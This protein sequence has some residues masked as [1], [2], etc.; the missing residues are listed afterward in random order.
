MNKL[1]L[2]AA[3]RTRRQIGVS[4][5]VEVI[6]FSFDHKRM[7]L[8]IVDQKD[9]PKAIAAG[10]QPDEYGYISIDCKHDF[11]NDDIIYSIVGNI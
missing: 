1:F 4:F 2:V 10:L 5:E 9:K 6:E 3:M 7:G 11:T 8:R